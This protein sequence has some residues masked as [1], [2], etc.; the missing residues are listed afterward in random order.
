MH[1]TAMFSDVAY[2]DALQYTHFAWDDALDH[3]YL[4]MCRI[5]LNRIGFTGPA[6][7]S[8]LARLVNSGA[9]DN[10]PDCDSNIAPVVEVGLHPPSGEAVLGG[11][12]GGVGGEHVADTRDLARRRVLHECSVP[13]SS[14][15]EGPDA[16]PGVEPGSP[17][18]DSEDP[19]SLPLANNPPPREHLGQQLPVS[20]QQLGDDRA[21]KKVRDRLAKNKAARAK[22]AATKA[23]K[24]RDAAVAKMKAAKDKYEQTLAGVAASEAAAEEAAALAEANANFV[25]DGG[26]DNSRDVAWTDAS[27]AALVELRLRWQVHFDD[28]M[29]KNKLLW[30]RLYEQ[31][32]SEGF[33]A[34]RGGACSVWG[35]FKN[36]QRDFRKWCRLR[37]S[38]EMGQDSGLS[39][40]EMIEL[41]SAAECNTHMI[42]IRH[43]QVRLAICVCVVVCV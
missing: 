6:V 32:L 26:A 17:H 5:P 35:K 23:S 21:A 30:G 24:Q 10:A 33:A 2:I 28:K 39:R 1:S 4:T 11:A 38:V 19:P 14:E 40:D 27:V 25:D 37:T 16:H 15:D 29:H 43:R 8:G 22:T 34:R 12:A 9:F 20:Q 41:L 18:G 36:E 31:L 42:F 3:N 7:S 13:V